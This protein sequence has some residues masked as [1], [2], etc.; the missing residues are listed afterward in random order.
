MLTSRLVITTV[1]VVQNSKYIYRWQG[2]TVA[3]SSFKTSNRQEVF[4]DGKRYSYRMELNP[5]GSIAPVRD[6]ADV[7]F[8]SDDFR[9]DLYDTKKISGGIKTG[10]RLLDD[11]KTYKFWKD[12]Q[13]LGQS[14]G[15]GKNLYLGQT[16]KSDRWR[17]TTLMQEEIPYSEESLGKQRIA[18]DQ[19][20]AKL[21]K[22]V[23][24]GYAIIGRVEIT[25]PNNP[26]QTK[27]V[28]EVKMYIDGE[29][30]YKGPGMTWDGYHIPYPEIL[31]M[32]Q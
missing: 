4:E 28:N 17:A 15:G 16:G 10:A 24:T 5:D 3:T 18:N 26:S 7:N 21:N 14:G 32:V 19:I 1:F 23:T 8:V 9:Y 30:V 25:N 27:E 6:K 11:G 2:K 29:D 31:G 12:G 22:C 13:V 20:D